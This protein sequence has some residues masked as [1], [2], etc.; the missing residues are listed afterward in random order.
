M[1]PA[2]RKNVSSLVIPQYQAKTAIE[3]NRLALNHYALAIGA[4]LCAIDG[5]INLIEKRAFLALFPYFSQQHL[6]IFKSCATDESSVYIHCKRFSKFSNGNKK[7]AARLFAR[8][9][10]L[11]TIDEPINALEISFLEKI[12]PMLGLRS[13]ILEKAL[14]IYFNQEIKLPNR[15][16]LG[17]TK[18]KEFYRDQVV[19]LHPDM[20]ESADFISG[21][22]KT[23]IISLANERT[24]RINENYQNHIS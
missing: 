24:K 22:L 9:F 6:S 13:T 5:D 1:L 19:K 21:K 18:M 23:K 4:K 11:A 12:A 7:A 2:L 17:K 10:K 16:L 20:F 3:T 8:L 14:E 15:F